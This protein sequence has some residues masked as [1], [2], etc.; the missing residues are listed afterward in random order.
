MKR[1]ILASGSPRRR[2]ILQQLGVNFEV[3]PSD[4]EE[5]IPAGLS[6]GDAAS[7]LALEKARDVALK[8]NSPSII[9]GADTI[10]VVDGEILGKP[11]DEAEACLML[12]RL[13]GREHEVI[14]GIAIIDYDRNI[15]IKDFESTRVKMKRI[16]PDRIERY[17]KTGEPLDKAGAYAAQGKASTFIEGIQG[18]F[19]NVVGLPISKLDSLLCSIGIDLF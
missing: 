19:F 5:T 18:C 14:T 3:L 7:Y 15:E 16:P 8:I 11:N 12:K 2:E 13:S 4:I 9:L 1:L 17:V 6:A 10:V